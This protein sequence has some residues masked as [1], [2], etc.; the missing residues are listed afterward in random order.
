M[1]E[2]VITKEI[3]QSSLD[4]ISQEM[5]ATMRKT[6]MSSIIYEVLDFG[7]AITD[8]N[9]ELASSGAGIPGFVGMLDC[10]VR[11]I[12]EKFPS[13]D[14]CEKDVF[15]TNIPQRGGASH[16]NDVVLILPVFYKGVLI[17][18][19]ANK[20]H[21][22]DIGGMSPGSIDPNAT[23]LYQEGLQIPEIKIIAGGEV[24]QPVLDV[25]V[26]NS[27]LPKT[28]MGD[29]W[30]GIA[31]IRTGEKRLVELAGK[32]GAD[33]FVKAVSD[34][35]EY[36]E[37]VTLRALAELP[38]GV[39]E[40][41][42]FLDDGRRFCAAVTITDDEFT[43]DL[44]GNPPQDSGPFNASYAG[45]LVDVQMV[46]KA[47]TDP[48]S[49][50]N[51]GT[52]RPLTLICDENSILN[53]RYP[54]AMGLYY[55]TS[56]RIF[57]TIW[58]ALAPHIPHRL[59][60]GHY[61]SICGT[62]LGG[63]HPDTGK[64]HSFIEPEVGGWGAACDADGDN[65]QFTGFHGQTF[66]CPVEVNESR[67]GIL[68]DQFCLNDE[69]GGEGEHR[70]G[71]GI[72]L[73][74]KIRSDDWWLTAVYSRF[75]FPPWGLGGGRDGSTNGIEIIRTN[76]AVERHNS[77]SGL[78]LDAGDVVRIITAAGG[79]YGNPANRKLSAVKDD[80]KNGYVTKDAAK[81]VYGYSND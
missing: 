78:V 1:S 24:I 10:G 72:V 67:N 65:A 69:P 37:S 2:S 61:A 54:A 23:D 11:A 48:Q 45:T 35:L 14:I 74:Y 15:M 25:I 26:A 80:I 63:V 64:P 38:K 53:S 39:F 59:T 29:F 33:V 44:R 20:A 50:A 71:R 5:F 55:E 21:W 9:G 60:A 47:I 70:G 81:E 6:A 68:V 43:V 49:V 22:V 31:S 75:K 12:I 42:D 16:M 56:I 77:C 62:I 51:A 46:L 7:V 79:G 41:E 28:T 66:N 27:R 8:A 19:L 17:A 36:A 32:Y 40:A 58:K 3:I 4:A 57:D 34:Y 30:A 73:D 13:T 18:W 52:F 76:G